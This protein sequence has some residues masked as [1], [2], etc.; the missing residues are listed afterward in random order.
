[1]HFDLQYVKTVYCWRSIK[2]DYWWMHFER[3]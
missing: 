2:L 3:I 1:M